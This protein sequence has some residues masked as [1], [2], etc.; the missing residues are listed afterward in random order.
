MTAVSTTTVFWPGRATLGEGPLWDP[1][2][3]TL[4]WVDIVAGAIFAQAA[5]VH[6]PTRIDVGVQLG[7]LGLTDD[8]RVLVAGMRTGWHL[9]KHRRSGLRQ[10]EDEFIAWVLESPPLRLP[11]AAVIF[12]AAHSGIPL[13]L[14]HH[15]RRMGSDESNI[16]ECAAQSYEEITV[17]LDR[18]NLSA[19]HQL[20]P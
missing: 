19:C 6:E 10:R 12:T 16:A 14:T 1:R 15:L 13:A 2:I 20:D 3:G 5:D 17:G 8:P 7:C 9:L 4:Y 11:G 18:G